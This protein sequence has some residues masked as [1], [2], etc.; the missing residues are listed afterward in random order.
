MDVTVILISLTFTLIFIILLSINESNVSHISIKKTNIVKVNY[1]DDFI[2]FEASLVLVINKDESIYLS[3]D[4]GYNNHNSPLVNVINDSN[5]KCVILYQ[6]KFFQNFRN[7]FCSKFVK[8]HV[9]L[10]SGKVIWI[11]NHYSHS[12]FINLPE[13]TTTT[14][15]MHWFNK[16]LNDEHKAAR[17]QNRYIESGV[18]EQM[19]VYKK[20]FGEINNRMVAAGFFLY[21]HSISCENMFKMWWFHN[22]IL[23]FEDQMSI[24]ILMNTTKCT[25]EINPSLPCLYLA[26]ISENK[27]FR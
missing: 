19:S 6:Q 14:F 12:N 3:S 21:K 27:C 24:V 5:S 23:S 22:I 8:T 20:K 7:M 26:N 18:D 1:L 10:F 16:D 4:F 11:D 15:F 25:F 9:Y 2:H 17:C 13:I